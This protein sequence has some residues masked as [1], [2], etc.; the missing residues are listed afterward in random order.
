M[1]EVLK[2][3]RVKVLGRVQG[4]SFRVWTRDQATKLGLTGWVRNEPD[5]SVTAMISGPQDAVAVMIERLHQGPPVASVSRVV[6][7]TVEVADAFSGFR[8]SR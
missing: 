3:V 7:E 4:V 1:A 5:G 2:T 8:I 6:A